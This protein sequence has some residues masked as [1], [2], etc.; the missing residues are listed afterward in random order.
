[1][2][3]ENSRNEVQEFIYR[4][5]YNS[6]W[7]AVSA[8]LYIHPTTLNLNMCR[9]HYPN[10]A[11]LQDMILEYTTNI[12]IDEDH[13]NFDAI[14]S[15]TIE[16]HEDDPY[17][18]IHTAETSQ[19][20]IAS[21]VATITDKLDELTISEIKPW[22]KEYKPV[23]GIA[24]SKNIVPIL[25]KKDL[26]VEATAFLEKYCPEVLVSPMPVPIEK[27]QRRSF[28]LQCIKGTVSQ[29]ISVFLGRSVFPTEPSNYKISSNV[30]KKK[31]L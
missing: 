14:L 13:L 20:L 28:I 24:A 26:D 8:Y 22:Q 31:S 16:L 12:S 3:V 23:K 27:S 21:C 9:I 5:C 6:I 18:D 7:S 30:V 11:I 15:C 29:A 10:S 1:M 17:R 2:E 4:F 19:W 25:Y